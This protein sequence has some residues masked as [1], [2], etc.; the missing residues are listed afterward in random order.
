MLLICFSAGTTYAI[1]DPDLIS[2]NTTQQEGKCSGVVKDATGE[3][4]IGASVKVKGQI[5]GG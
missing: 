4:I 5:M 1:S 2:M 3:P